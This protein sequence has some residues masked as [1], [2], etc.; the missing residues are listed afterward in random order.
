MPKTAT[1]IPD[2]YALLE[3]S[4]RA[5]AEVIK[6][7]YETLVFGQDPSM[8]R[9]KTLKDAFDILGDPTKRAEHDKKRAPKGDNIIGNYR[10]ISQIAEGGFGTT[11]RAEHLITKEIV[12]IKHCSSVSA[13][14]DAVLIQE[15]RILGTLRHF[16]L[17]SMRDMIRLDDGSLALVMSYIEGPT[18]E[19]EVETKGRIDPYDMGWI[20]ERLLNALLFLHRFGVIH[21][22]LK[23]QNI[24]LQWEH[25]G[26]VLV[27]FGLSQVKPTSKTRGNGYT[28]LFAPPEQ[29]ALKP[30][31]P[32]SDYYSLGQCMIYGLGGGM[33]AV[34]KVE[35]PTTVPEP[36]CRFI[37]KLT[38]KHPLDRPQGDL[39]DAFKAIR[40]KAFGQIRPGTRPASGS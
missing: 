24:I 9:F 26:V 19:Q 12:C 31:I 21:G 8:A 5:S 14:H 39:F 38:A 29:L 28:E 32:A 13:A 18:L 30:L 36:M 27:D 20:T 15:A 3:V 34:Q 16:A 22:D 17:P 1:P 40:E 10:I 2:P 33:K 37:K 23:P 7:A 6:A 35:V 25:H 4:P 11:F